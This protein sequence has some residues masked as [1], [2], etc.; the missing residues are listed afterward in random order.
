VPR[1]IASLF[2]LSILIPALISSCT[3]N[4]VAAPRVRPGEQS[5]GPVSIGH[6]HNELAR[7]YLARRPAAGDISTE[8]FLDLYVETSIEVCGNLGV[9]YTPSRL[10]LDG[11]LAQCERWKQDGIIDIFDP[12]RISPYEAVDRMAESGI[13]PEGDRHHLKTIIERMELAGSEG[14]K[15]SPNR[16]SFMPPGVDAPERIKLADDVAVHSCALWQEVYG[17]TPVKVDLDDHLTAEWWKQVTKWIATGI[18]DA[19]AAWASSTAFG[20]NPGAVALFTT[21]ASLAAYEAF[22]ERGW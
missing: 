5:A 11:F 8:E 7:A 1:K 3:D 21:V 16:S 22:V 2:A 14:K 4:D 12:T 10:E 13:I 6:L 18:C 9:D 19:L 20:G 17:D 15:I